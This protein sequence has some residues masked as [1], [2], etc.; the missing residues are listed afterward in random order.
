MERTKLS[1][2]REDFSL[3]IEAGFIAVKQFDEAASTRIFR[4]AQVLNPE[5]TAPK[6]GLGYIAFNKLD[7]KE[8]TRIFEEVV[9]KEPENNLAQVFLGMSYLLNKAKRQEGEELIKSIVS[10]T[11]EATLQHLGSLAL[12][13]SDKELKKTK[14]PFFQADELKGV[15]KPAHS[16]PHPEAT[17]E[18]AAVEETPVKAEAPSSGASAVP[19]SKAKKE[20]RPKAKKSN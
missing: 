18:S 19:E 11:Q 6:I 12:E 2:F 3:L 17:K 16:A 7:V 9:Q 13:W 1:D 14:G 15:V 5:S 10:K 4:A 8:A 20:I